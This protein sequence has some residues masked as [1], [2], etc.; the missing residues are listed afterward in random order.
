MSLKA[1]ALAKSFGNL[2]VLRSVS[3]ECPNGRVTALVGAN[4][5]GKTTLF[6][7]LLGLS[8]ADAGTVYHN[9]GQ[10][11][12][13]GGFVEK[14]ALYSYLSAWQN[15][16]LF[17][18]LNGLQLSRSDIQQKLEQVGLD[19][20]RRDPVRNYSMGMKQRLGIAVSLLKDPDTLILDE[21]FSGLD[22]VGIRGL[23]ELL[24]E[25]ARKKD[26]AVL[27]SSH[28]VDQLIKF[29]DSFYVIREGKILLSASSRELVT[30]YTTGYLVEA[31]GIGKSVT[32]GSLGLTSE[33]DSAYI[34]KAQF[35]SM[36]VLGQLIKEGIRINAC[37]PLLDM[38]ELFEQKP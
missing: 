30:R 16:A 3:M 9:A 26:M 24:T 4:G 32:I 17:G 25:L 29:C 23:S 12:S 13:V 6:K 34:P 37:I 20:R 18:R 1:S 2:E 33:P 22:P 14:P 28:F 27:I 8:R 7:I 15:M 10:L 35:D 11:T 31:S 19:Y 21:P 5:A 38:D 36:D